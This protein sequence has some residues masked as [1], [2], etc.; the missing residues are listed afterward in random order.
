M[1]VEVARQVL[2]L[3]KDALSLA[4]PAT[5]A[6]MVATQIRPGLTGGFM[7][8]ISN[9]AALVRGKVPTNGGVPGQPGAIEVAVTINP[10]QYPAQPGSF[11]VNVGVAEMFLGTPSGG[12]APYSFEWDFGDGS[13][14]AV[15]Q[16]TKT[17][18]SA[19]A[20]SCSVRA[21]DATGAWGEFRFT[22]NAVDRGR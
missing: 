21:T 8:F 3:V 6:F 11:A 19:G 16:P 4:E 7:G 13:V 1:N 2:D 5:G 14:S 9:E 12:T 15:A 17:F 20:Y 18:A 22:V 10:A